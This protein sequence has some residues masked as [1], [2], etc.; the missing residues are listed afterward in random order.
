MRSEN[1][2]I[3]PHN[4]NKRFCKRFPQRRIV[5][6]GKR[7]FQP[8]SSDSVSTISKGKYFPKTKSD[9][10][11]TPMFSKRNPLFG[12][13]IFHKVFHT[14]LKT[15]DGML[16]FKNFKEEPAISARIFSH[17]E[18]CVFAFG[19]K[20]KTSFREQKLRD[21]MWKGE[22]QRNIYRFTVWG[23]GG[24]P[25]CGG[26]GRAAPCLSYFLISRLISEISAFRAGSFFTCFST[27][28]MFECTVE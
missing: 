4:F 18:A 25:P 13:H 27:A 16:K 17:A 9:M 26:M 10:E 15:R 8:F 3:F 2:Q 11:W 20:P 1:V 12:E 24:K 5:S 14:L 22:I 6:I 28:V 19:K 21:G 23:Q 7:S